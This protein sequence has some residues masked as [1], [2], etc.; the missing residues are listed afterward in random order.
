MSSPT[1]LRASARFLALVA[2]LL[3]A[4]AMTAGA[5]AQSPERLTIEVVSSPPEFVSG[6]DA[7]MVVRVPERIALSDVTVWDGTHQATAAFSPRAG[8]HALEGVISGLP[9]GATLVT[10]FAGPFKATLEIVNHDV[11]GPMFSGPAQ[12]VFVC[13]TESHRATAGLGEVLDE[14]CS[15][16]RRTDFLYFSTTTGS[17]EVFD[18]AAGVPA[19]VMQVPGP[20]GEQPFVVRWE[21]GTINRF[22]YSIAIPSPFSQDVDAP[23]L[24]GWN[25]KLVYQFQ[26]GVGIGHYQ[27]SPSRGNMLNPQLLGA[28]YAIAYS[29]GTRTSVHYDLIV[30]GETAI[31]VKD[32]FVSAYADPLYTVGLGGSGGGIQQY[33][34]AQNHP[35]LLDALIPQYSY[36]DMVTQTIHVADC[37][38]L[39][40]FMDAKVAAD[41]DSKWATWT[42]RT[43]LQGMNASDELPNPY[44]QGAPGLTECING[45]RGLSALA[46]N[47]HFGTAPGISAEQQASVHWTYFEDIVQVVGR[48]DDGFART[49]WDNVGVQYG[50]QA[51]LDGDISPAE[52]LELNA[53]VGGWKAQAEMVQEGCPFIEQLCADAAQFDPSSS[54]NMNLADGDR[55]APRTEGDLSAIQA[56]WDSG[57]VFIGD[58]LGVPT[59]DWRPYLE[60]QLDMHNTVQ[61][62]ATRQ[63]IIDAGGDTGEMVIWFTDVADGEDEFDQTPLA[64]EVIDEWLANMREDPSLSVVQARPARAVDA[65]FD[66]SGELIYAGEDAWSGI[67]DDGAEGACASEFEIYSNTRMVAGGPITLDVFK[68]VLM[69]VDEAISRGVYGSWQPSADERA[70]LM[71]I[72]PTGVC[73]YEAGNVHLAAWFN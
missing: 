51:L 50:L 32:R 2:A 13:A 20:E 54:R 68:C 61:S 35:G 48:D 57:L 22:I 23:D 29:T 16:E 28:G 73:D 65:C 12:E 70:R 25:G 7:R 37:E 71:E 62:F 8:E 52:F 15:L 43:L 3:A 27:G 33:V 6:G 67:L 39:E 5:L 44:R 49:S 26:G 34:Y 1:Y 60:R 66:A 19:D 47:P 45:W 41:P 30:G 10:A 18:P 31:M 36:P 58:R 64:L 11:R 9:V 17:F 63:R 24:A 69:S 56:I 72:F 59:I 40:R 42:N 55:P 46:L 4:M 53:E 38:L 14:D 21:R